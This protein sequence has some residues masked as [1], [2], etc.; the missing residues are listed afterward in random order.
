MW[1]WN[2]G[3]SLVYDDHGGCVVCTVLDLDQAAVFSVK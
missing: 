1:C 2:L 3:F